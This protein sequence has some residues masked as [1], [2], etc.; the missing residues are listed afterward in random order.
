M[1][2][3]C[4]EAWSVRPA[5]IVL[6]RMIA[7]CSKA[8]IQ[9]AAVVVTVLAAALMPQP[10][11]ATYCAALASKQYTLSLPPAVSK[12]N[13]EG[14]PPPSI[15]TFMPTRGCRPFGGPPLAA[16]SGESHQL[17]TPEPTSNHRSCHPRSQAPDCFSSGPAKRGRSFVGDCSPP[18][19]GYPPDAFGLG[20][21]G[22]GFCWAGSEWVG[23]T[24]AEE[25][26]LA[27]STGVALA[28]EPCESPTGD[29]LG[30]R[31]PREDLPGRA[32]T[33]CASEGM[34]FPEPSGNALRPRPL[35]LPPRVETRPGGPAAAA[36]ACASSSSS[37]TRAWAFTGAT[38]TEVARF[39]AAM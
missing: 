20:A 18:A 10:A 33:G 29:L 3:S 21:G 13:C 24:L 6:R 1:G 14:E 32:G 26:P 34:L 16:S 39:F 27:G 4:S 35:A 37:S 23:T 38:P 8:L 31:A 12:V 28:G 30:E 7:S 17:R 2:A 11:L 15:F 19:L 22:A 36:S 9:S 5:A 25:W